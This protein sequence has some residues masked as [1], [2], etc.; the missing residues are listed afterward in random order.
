MALNSTLYPNLSRVVSGA[1]V[2]FENDSII[3]C[4]TSAAPVT[5][6]LLT[7]PAGFWQTTWKLYITD[8]SN[9]AGTNNI[10]INAPSGYTINGLPSLIIKINGGGATITIGSDTAFFASY[11]PIITIADAGG[12]IAPSTSKITFTNAT[13]VATSPTEVT[14]TTSG[15]GGGVSSVGATLPLSSTGGASPVISMPQANAGQDGY[16]SLGDFNT[17]SGKVSSVK[18]RLQ[19]QYS[20]PKLG[21]HIKNE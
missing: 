1:V 6:T 14:I 9:N 12:I 21:A 13:V 16:L 7:I 8:I 3:L 11:Y 10:T 17:F 19:I 4:N 18:R 20:L 15:G 5:M 2:L